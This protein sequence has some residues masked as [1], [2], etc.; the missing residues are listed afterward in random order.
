MEKLLNEEYEKDF[1]HNKTGDIYYTL[2]KAK[3]T[4]NGFENQTMIV[5][6]N[7]AGKIFAREEKEFLIKFTESKPL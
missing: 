4:T 2:C 3:N 1:I 7:K 6:A 5:Y